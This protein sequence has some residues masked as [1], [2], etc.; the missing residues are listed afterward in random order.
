M[1]E[2]DTSII[3]VRLGWLVVTLKAIKKRTRYGVR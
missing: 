2:C 3:F 1:L